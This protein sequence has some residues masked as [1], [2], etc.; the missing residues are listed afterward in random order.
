MI[1]RSVW[2]YNETLKTKQ[3]QLPEAE[4]IGRGS[5]EASRQELCSPQSLAASIHRPGSVRKGC[6]RVREPAREKPGCLGRS[7]VSDDCAAGMAPLTF[8]SL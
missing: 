8:P 4:G 2:L 3:K 1:L 6:P 7:V 5:R